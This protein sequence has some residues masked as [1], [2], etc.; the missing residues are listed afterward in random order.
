MIISDEKA[1][2]L[3]KIPVPLFCIVFQMLNVQVTLS[4]TNSFAQWNAFEALH[5][6]T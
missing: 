2:F 4:G 3:N 1:I 6:L 5:F